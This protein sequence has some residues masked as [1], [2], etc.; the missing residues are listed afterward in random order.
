M[1]DNVGGTW[2][3]KHIHRT[4][5]EVSREMN[6]LVVISLFYMQIQSMIFGTI[7]ELKA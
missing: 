6:V 4:L 2:H 1:M 7:S 3:S 5:H